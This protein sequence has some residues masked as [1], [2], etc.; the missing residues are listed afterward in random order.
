MYT[1]VSQVDPFRVCLTWGYG[2][3]TE[4]REQVR[5]DSAVDPAI[6]SVFV[7]VCVYVETRADA[8]RRQDGSVTGYHWGG[9]RSTTD[10]SDVGESAI[11]GRRISRVRRRHTL[12]EELIPAT[13]VPRASQ[14]CLRKQLGKPPAGGSQLLVN[15]FVP[16]CD[17]IFLG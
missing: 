14:G 1:R 2:H 10:T 6:L 16:K 11:P 15:S 12:Y 3:Q 5:Y 8:R 7:C 13:A 4:H 9:A 17:V